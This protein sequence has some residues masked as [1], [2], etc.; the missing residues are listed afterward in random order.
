MRAAILTSVETRHRFFVN[1]MARQL[2]VVAVVYEQTGYS[3][4]RTFGYGLSKEEESVVT[5]HFDERARQEELF[6]GKEASWLREQTGTRVIQLV[7]GALNSPRTLD[8]VRGA[9][10]DVLLVYGTNLIRDPLLSTFSG[11]IVNLHLGLSPYYRGTATNFYPLLNEEPEYVGATIHQI[12]AG[13]DS[14]PILAQVRP[15]IVAGDQPHTIGCKAILAGVNRMA[16]IVA[17]WHAGRLTPVPQWKPT[18]T[19]LYLR[20]DYHPRQV[21]ELAQKMAGGLIDR[22]LPEAPRRL[23]AVKLVE[24]S[25]YVAC[26]SR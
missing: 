14:G 19:R 21:V 3:P 22:W 2:D 18:R 11:R 9:K 23:A 4:A 16:S 7:P 12:D 6:Y 17:D 15:R 26:A 8:F 20:K 10:P 5:A 25:Y 1:A 13:I 24:P